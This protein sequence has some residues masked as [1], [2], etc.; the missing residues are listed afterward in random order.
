MPEATALLGILAA[1]QHRFDEAQALLE[2]AIA[3]RADVPQWHYELRQV[4]RRG[5]HLDAAL[6]AATEAVRLDPVNPRY[7]N[8]LGQ[9]HVD[10]AEH[11]AAIG[12]FM[13]ALARAPGDTEAH[14]SLAHELLSRGDYR[15][16]FMEYEWRFRAALYKDALPTITR[17]Q[18]NGMRLPGKRL[19]L[20]ADQGYGD[21]FH[22]AR[23][24]RLAAERCGG[25][26]LLCRSPQIP[27]FA[28]LPGVEACI[29]DI[30][31]AGEHAAFC[32]MASLPYIFGTELA[33]IPA[34]TPYLSPDPTRRS[35]WRE[36]LAR[37]LP[38][39]GL[40]VGLVWAGNPENSGD[41]RRSIR[42]ERLRDLGAIPGL[43]LVSL[44]KPI[45]QID[46]ADFAALGLEDLSPGLTDFG[47]TAAAIANLDLVVTVD[48]GVAHLAGAI[49]VP[50]WVLI[51]HPADWRWLLNRD[52][53]PW[54]PSLRLFR[55]PVAGD[56]ATPIARLE[57][58]LASLAACG[59]PLANP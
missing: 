35:A 25:I 40:R 32:W 29:T 38:E 52:D 5:F 54:Y 10:R 56:W 37:R 24:V 50:A 55:Q 45:P 7:W 18:W 20:G 28:R 46:R 39:T 19:L 11:G 58:A 17:P 47:E 53:S 22:F 49:G 31:K 48:S 4:H 2:T 59:R 51:H 26:V 34:A 36:E 33:T 13:N 43:R 23:Y 9:I 6:A 15:A 12:C 3:A 1:R 41:W 30:T 42:L 14:L 27:L 16:G 8:G 57:A 44:Q 21:S